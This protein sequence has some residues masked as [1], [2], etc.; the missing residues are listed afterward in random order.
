MLFAMSQQPYIVQFAY[1]GCKVLHGQRP[2]QHWVSLP[3][4]A[5]EASIITTPQLVHVH[6]HATFSHGVKHCT[7][8]K[9]TLNML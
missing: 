1:V 8:V 3:Q 6:Q 5:D 9:L 2:M 7:S 4:L